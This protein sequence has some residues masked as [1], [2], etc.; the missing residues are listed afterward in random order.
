MA[1]YS[2]LEL[3]ISV[4]MVLLWRYVLGRHDLVESYV[5][6][7]AA[8]RFLP[9]FSLGIVVYAVLIRRVVRQ[10]GARARGE[11]PGRAV[12]RLRPAVDQNIWLTGSGLAA[13]AQ[14]GE[15]SV[16]DRSC[17]EVVG[18]V[19]IVDGAGLT[20][21]VDAEGDLRHAEGRADPRE[22]V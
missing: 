16:D 15:S 1:I 22:G 12:L 14:S 21:F 5:D 19:E 17:V 6:G 20:E 8:R 10:R 4:V 18:A 2:L 11:F 13:E 9:Q 3:A 7:D